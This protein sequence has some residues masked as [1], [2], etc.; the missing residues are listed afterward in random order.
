M[1]SSHK[2]LFLF[3]ML[4]GISLFGHN[5]LAATSVGGSYST[6]QHWTLAGSPY[7]VDVPLGEGVIIQSGVTLTIDRGV[8]V[9][10][11]PSTQL[12]VDGTVIARGTV[13][14]PIVFTSFYD[15][16]V[17]GDTDGTGPTTG[18][19]GDWWRIGGGLPSGNPHLEFDHTLVRY[20]GYGFDLILTSS[21]I[22]VTNS[23]I[24][25]GGYGFRLNSNNGGLV[26]ENNVIR[27][28]GYG[29]FFDQIL[30]P[31][32][33]VKNNTISSNSFRGA[34]NLTPAFP[35]DMR[36]NSWGD[37][38]GPFHPTLN[39]SGLGNQVSDGIFFDP[40]L[41]KSPPPKTPV[42]IVPGIYGTELWNGNEFIWANLGRM[43]TDINDQFLTE[44]LGLDGEGNSLNAITTGDIEREI[45]TVDI[46]QSLT[47]TLASSGYQENEN[48]FVFPYDWRL[49]LDQNTAFL[50]QKIRAVKLITGVS[51][52]D[53]ITHSMGGLLAKDYLNQYGKD[54][55]DKLIFVG[56][57][58]LG[59]PK[60]A[61]AIL[62][63][64]RVNIPWLE[65]DRIQELAHN[66]V[67]AHELL[68]NRKYFDE[69][70]GYLKKFSFL[71]QQPILD[72]DQ[73]KDFLLND[74]GFNPTVF[75]K[76]E[77]FF[78]KHLEDYDF[79][80]V[81]AYNIAGCRTGTQA[82]YQLGISNAYIWQTKYTSGDGTV[83]LPSADYINLS[84][85]NKFYVKNADHAE[86]SS[87]NGVRELILGILQ[88]Q[89][90]LADNISHS[91]S[92][93]NFKGK[94]LLWRSPVAVH[95]YDA[96]GRHTGPIENNGIE[97]AIPGVDYDII[98]EEKFIFLPT[99]E[100]QIYQIIAQG[101]ADSTFDLLISENDN[102]SVLATNVFNDVVITPQT[103]VDFGVADV[104]IPASIQVDLLGNGDD[105]IIPASAELIG[106]Q[107][108]DVVPPQTQAVVSGLVGLNGW[109]IGETVI[110]F[111]VADD[112]SGVLETLYSL[113]GGLTFFIYS[114][115]VIITND[116]ITDIQ[117]YSVDN[118]GNNE[119]IKTVQVKIDQTPPEVGAQFDTSTRDFQ[120]FATD[121]LDLGPSLTCV[122][123]V[124]QAKDQ[125]GNEIILDFKKSSIRGN[126][127][128][129][130]KNVKYNGQ[131]T[132][133]PDNSLLI[134]F[135][136]QRGRIKTFIQ[137]FSLN[138]NKLLNITYDP[139]K[140]QSIVTDWSS[141][142]AQ[143]YTQTGVKFLQVK[144]D[145]GIIKAEVK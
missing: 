54:D 61:K 37:P 70:T 51:K 3:L 91:Q 93:C 45:F 60:A 100:G 88:D 123:P 64:D 128:L 2:F 8:I 94:E 80:G 105:Q 6:D 113:D 18:W 106:E 126:K 7:I 97:Y 118:A 43:F 68:P 95:I 59:A 20:S 116:G 57:P 5:A 21:P 140:D 34:Y 98:G 46:F 143:T 66:S 137:T 132:V 67:S 120:F 23:V 119:D 63:G 44:N 142:D 134:S 111:S 127:N 131:N 87:T 122:D 141:G 135:S 56:T 50:D 33:F 133:L 22:A 92:F 39:P 47:K 89:I 42:I 48:L 72:Y 76:A 29:F 108:S 79:S 58:H 38:S 121:N 12:W 102:G 69:F 25:N 115:P 53:L 41:E 62:F 9:K 99:D 110:S 55:I 13:G 24:E 15:D 11:K 129:S 112:N 81:D 74:K 36:N 52:V 10:F 32:D 49:N 90:A 4:F 78:S 130:F 144:T 136:Q 16:S 71:Q 138:L 107:G 31:S 19:S 145:G 17:G 117:F 82:G 40:W 84:A 73:T 85:D 75:A 30:D 65:D 77:D 27:N 109:F 124:C 104:G 14:E 139:K 83:P 125:A 1:R 101:L 35:V 28:N 26:I 96:S 114:L 103:V 86:L